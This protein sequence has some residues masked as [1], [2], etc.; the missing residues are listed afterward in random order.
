MIKTVIV[1]ALQHT[2]DIKL[3]FKQ[4]RYDLKLVVWR[5]PHTLYYG[6][7]IT[8]T[9]TAEHAYGGRHTTPRKAYTIIH[10]LE[11]GKT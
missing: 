3:T 4:I 8:R 7:S 9:T 6:R 10:I 11:I 1:E 5:P 2:Y